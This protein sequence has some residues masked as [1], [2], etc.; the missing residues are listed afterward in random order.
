[1]IVSKDSISIFLI[2]VNLL[3]HYVLHPFK[4]RAL[5]MHAVSLH[6]FIV[7]LGYKNL[8]FQV[9]VPSLLL[10]I[11]TIFISL[12]IVTYGFLRLFAT[13]II[14]I[15]ISFLQEFILLLVLLLSQEHLL[16]V[17]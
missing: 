17:P 4:Y 3:V 15:G 11:L 8:G 16:I 6:L 2:E 10:L 9:P 1:M 5:V 7:A 13:A 12:F 14:L